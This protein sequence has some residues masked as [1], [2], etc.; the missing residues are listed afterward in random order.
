MKCPEIAIAMG[1]VTVAMYYN[2]N[3][4]CITS[5]MFPAA[6]SDMRITTI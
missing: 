3:L 2:R 6:V 4:L 5:Q 1:D